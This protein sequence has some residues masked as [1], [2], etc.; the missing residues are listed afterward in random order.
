MVTWSHTFPLTV[1]I[2][3]GTILL[4]VHIGI[5]VVPSQSSQLMPEAPFLGVQSP[6]NV[7]AVGWPSC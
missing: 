7:L 6:Q 2:N 1:Q 5:I 4:S 3:K